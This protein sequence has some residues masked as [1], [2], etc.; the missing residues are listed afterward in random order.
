NEG[1][2]VFFSSHIIEVV[3]RICDRIAIISGGKICQCSTMEEI[4]ASGKSLE[5]IY[6]QYID[7]PEGKL[8][9]AE[10][11]EDKKRKAEAK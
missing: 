8:L 6:L 5:E 10:R 4:R 2:I 3:E 11:A 9:A 7:G 1:N